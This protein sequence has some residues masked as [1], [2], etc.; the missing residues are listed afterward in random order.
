MGSLCLQVTEKHKELRY[1]ESTLG[2]EEVEV[3]TKKDKEENIDKEKGRGK[4][5]SKT[6]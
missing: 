1:R 5:H 2:E 4:A 3:K 6:K